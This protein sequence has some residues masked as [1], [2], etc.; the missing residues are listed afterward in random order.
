MTNLFYYNIN[1]A[2][3]KGTSKQ[4]AYAET[5]REKLIES[6]NE[7]TVPQIHHLFTHKSEKVEKFISELKQLQ[8]SNANLN[9]QMVINRIRQLIANEENAVTFIENQ[10]LLSFLNT[11]LK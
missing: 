9:N 10:S 11:I 5:I 2:N 3:L 4:I 1:A 6:V 7:S 8:T